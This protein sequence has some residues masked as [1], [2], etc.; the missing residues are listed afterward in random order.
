[1]RKLSVTMS[2]LAAVSVTVPVFGA[3]QPET[4]GDKLAI[5]TANAAESLPERIIQLKAQIEK[6]NNTY[7]AEERR[8]LQERLKEA[9]DALRSLMKPGR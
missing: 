9:N 8:I 5:K 6:G 4:S 2:I 7:T 1:M 3:F